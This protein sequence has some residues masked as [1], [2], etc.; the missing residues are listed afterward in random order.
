MMDADRLLAR[1]VERQAAWNA[2]GPRERAVLL[3]RC[4]DAIATVAAAT[5]SSR[6]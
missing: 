3:R 5:R 2:V 1:L 6:C 4:N